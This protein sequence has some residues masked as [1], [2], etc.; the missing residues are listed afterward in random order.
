MD[1]KLDEQKLVADFRLLPEEGQKELLDLA[2]SLRKK[3]QE[4]ATEEPIRT[5][6]QCS[7]DKGPEK[8]PEAAKEPI[9]TE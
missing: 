6:N 7:L 5:E 9:F 3:Y 8:R 1:L 2:S 4:C